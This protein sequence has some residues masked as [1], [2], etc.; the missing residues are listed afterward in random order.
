MHPYLFSLPLPWLDAPFHV[1]SFGALVALGF[2]A[3]AHVLQRLAAR[4]GDDP[5]HDEDH[6][7]Q[8]IMWVLFG[9]FGGARLMYVAVEMLRGSPTGE[10][11]I[12]QPWT[13]FFFWQGGLVMYG[14][15]LG[16]VLAGIHKA[17][18]LG[19]R[20]LNAVDM[21]MVA[22]F[23]AQAI[24]RIGCLMVGDDYGRVVPE[25]YADLP[26]PLVIRV[27]DPLP[28]GSLFGSQNA[29]EILWATQT[30]MSL[31][32][33]ALSG[34]AFFILK[35]RRYT[36]QVLLWTVALYALGRYAIEAF[37]GDSIR[38]LWF[39]GA[40]STSQ[41]I[42]AVAGSLALVLIFMNRRR[43]DPPSEAARA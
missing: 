21:A 8:I 17:R 36:G 35:R 22:A 20:W 2:L 12:Q 30:W 29:G 7:A 5:E 25:K 10:G 19:V 13:M 11:Y 4:Y 9:V 18:K 40:M 3:G 26:F 1:R 34:V 41:L 28:E 37:R 16:G 32:A 39:D 27:P 24:G 6:F 42:S 23:F 15:F 14:G 31:N 43:S 38:G 33:L